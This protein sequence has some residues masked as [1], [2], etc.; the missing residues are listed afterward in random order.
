MN[1]HSIKGFTLIELSAVILIIGIIISSVSYG[2]NLA[3]QARLR[4][5]I[6]EANEY[7]E[8]INLF[9][10]KYGNL[11]GDIPTASDLWGTT[12]DATPSNCNGNGDGVIYYSSSLL[13]NEA[14][15]AWQHLS[16]AGMIRGSYTGIAS[17][18]NQT[19]IGVNAPE[20][21]YSNGGWSIYYHQPYNP[22]YD[23][24]QSLIIGMFQANSLPGNSLI[25]PLDAYNID[26]KIDDGL[27]RTGLVW[28][29]SATTFCFVNATYVDSPY[30]IVNTTTP[31][32]I[33]S[34]IFRK[35]NL[36]F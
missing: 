33:L 16:L 21:K 1:N 11:P 15:R 14:M 29:D 28:G 18:A 30:N 32:C 10:Q 31:A 34:F 8:A 5:V 6:T 36:W 13:K 2:L 20:S 7:M 19:D 17:I 23:T 9:E 27:P 26:T 22:P 3:D 24:G 35:P 12:C 4:S 25:I